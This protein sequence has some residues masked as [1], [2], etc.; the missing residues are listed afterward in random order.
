MDVHALESSKLSLH[1]SI[2]FLVYKACRFENFLKPHI[3]SRSLLNRL[4][5]VCLR[6]HRKTSK[7]D[8]RKKLLRD[9]KACGFVTESNWRHI[10]KSK[11][12]DIVIES[13]ERSIITVL[14][15]FLSIS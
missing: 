10:P 11:G 13:A 9:F 12:H 7:S 6:I 5:S 14:I 15:I 2:N 4:N 3:I 8:C 1:L